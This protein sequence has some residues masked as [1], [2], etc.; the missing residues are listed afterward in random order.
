MLEEAK[1]SN[2]GGPIALVGGFLRCEHC[3]SAFFVPSD[4]AAVSEDDGSSTSTTHTTT[5]HTTTMSSTWST[6]SSWSTMSTTWTR[7]E[8]YERWDR[9]WEQRE[10]KRKKRQ[11][12]LTLL[13]G[14]G[15][16]IFYALCGVA[17]FWDILELAQ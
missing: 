8:D 4:S 17:I 9:E 6:Q 1:C 5:T 15:W 3:R 16:C 12:R 2:C 11:A 13:V 10:A 7:L 14:I